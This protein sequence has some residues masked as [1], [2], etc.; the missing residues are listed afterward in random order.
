M[1]GMGVAL[2]SRVAI[3]TSQPSIEA[4]EEGV[5]RHMPIRRNP[6]LDPV[7]RSRHFLARGAAFDPRHAL[8]VFFPVKFEASKGE[9]SC[10]ARMKSAEAQAAGLLQGDLQCEFPQSIRE[11][12]VKPCRIAAELNGADQVV[13]VAAEQRLAST[14]GFDHF[15]KPQVQ[16][17]MQIDVG[18]HGR[19]DPTL[20]DPGVRVEHPAIRLQNPGFQPL[21]DQPQKGPVVDAHTQHPQP[22]VMVHVVEKAFNVGLYHIAIPPVW[23]VKGQVTDRLPCPASGPVPLTTPQKLLRIDRVQDSGAGRL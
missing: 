14:V 7:A 22:P 8:S 17:L 20:R 3:M 2:D 6:F 12:L 13:G 9:P 18:Y 11:R 5:P 15:S 19:D 1:E 16:R 23:Q 10:H 4:V 21:P